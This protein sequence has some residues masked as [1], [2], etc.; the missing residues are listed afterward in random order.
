VRAAAIPAGANLT[1]YPA[2]NTILARCVRGTSVSA[3]HWALV[4]LSV[5]LFLFL[6][7]TPHADT[8][9]VATFIDVG[10]GDCCWLHLP[11]GDDVLVDGG[12]P[13]AGPTV[14]AYLSQHGVT[15]IDL[16]IATHG[17]ADHIGG[18]LDVLA[19]MPV[20]QAWLDSHAGTTGTSSDFYQ[21][22]AENGVITATV[23][24]GQSCQWGQVTALVLNPSE[25]LFA[26]K[27]EN[28]IV[29]RVS[30]G[31]VDLLLTGDAE[32]GAEARMLNSGLPVDAEMLKVAH[33]GS[34]SSSSGEFLSAVA[35]QEA[36][37]SVGPNP[38]RHPR[39]EVLHRLADVGANVYRT[40][41]D[42]TITVTTNGTTWTVTTHRFIAYLPIVMKPLPT[43]TASPTATRTATRTPTRTPT[44]TRTPTVTPTRTPAANIVVTAW[45]SDSTPSQYS[46]VRVYGKITRGGAGIG[47]VPMVATWYYKTVTRYC[48]GTSGGNGVASCSR[49]ISGA[50]KRYYVAIKVTFTY[51]ARTYTA[52]TGFTPQ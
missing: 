37:I 5:I 11:N 40:D 21:A 52:W 39:A 38:Y 1:P 47:G 43:P 12:K 29:L 23:R 7:Q 6:W 13:Q 22:L 33:H 30:H 42:G 45:V 50:T 26:S 24:M 35:P 36:I 25:P 44:R 10:Q 3:R 48:E 51:Q 16:M 19:S 17:D 34:N 46:T 9:F 28:S 27:N 18:L 15:D 49:Y 41:L 14:V 20:Q 4:V 2:S 32:R 8:P 31:S